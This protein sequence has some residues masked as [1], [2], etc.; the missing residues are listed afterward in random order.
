M[1]EINVDFE[2]EG[3][4][5]GTPDDV[6]DRVKTSKFVRR[7]VSDDKHSSYIAKQGRNKT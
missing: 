2:S 6:Y 1:L 5:A 3:Q 4:F 7:R